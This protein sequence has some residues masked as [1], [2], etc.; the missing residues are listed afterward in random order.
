[1]AN[2]TFFKHQYTE[3]TGG[4]HPNTFVYNLVID[5]NTYNDILL[6]NM[7]LPNGQDELFKLQQEATFQTLLKKDLSEEEVKE[8]MSSWD[9][10]LNKNWG[11]DENNLLFTYSPYEAAPYA[12]GVID[13]AIPKDKLQDIIQPEYLNLIFPDSNDKKE[14]IK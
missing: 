9:I 11:F 5:P 3:Y 6:D 1:N 14:Q 7:F 12:Y 8:L 2:F 10:Q 4:A 13:I